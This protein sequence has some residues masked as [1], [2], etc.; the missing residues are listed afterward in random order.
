MIST[1]DD[2]FELNEDDVL[3]LLGDALQAAAALRL[4]AD[5]LTAITHKGNDSSGLIES[6][7]YGRLDLAMGAIETFLTRAMAVFPPPDTDSS[8]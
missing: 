4:V 6:D 8:D 3:Q 1:P 7:I 2:P 5:E